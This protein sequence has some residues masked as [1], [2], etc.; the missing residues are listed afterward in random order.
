MLHMQIFKAY[1]KFTT[2]ETQE[3]WCRPA[4]YSVTSPVHT[5]E[6]CSGMNTYHMALRWRVCSMDWQ[7]G[8][9]YKSQIQIGTNG[10]MGE[11]MCT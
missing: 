9:F 4:C 2:S 3:V 8:N 5:P 1:P 11:E 6:A 7:L 10:L